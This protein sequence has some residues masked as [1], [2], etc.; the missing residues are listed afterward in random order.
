MEVSAPTGWVEEEFSRTLEQS[1][2]KYAYTFEQGNPWTKT[3]VLKKEGK[4]LFQEIEGAW[5]EVAFFHFRHSKKW[6]L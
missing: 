5:K 1:G 4:S 6:P 2:L 3:P